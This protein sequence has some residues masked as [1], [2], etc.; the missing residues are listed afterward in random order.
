M[1]AGTQNGIEA[2][3]RAHGLRMT[4]PRRIILRILDT[5]FDHPD[6]EELHRRAV[7]IDARIALSTVYRTMRLLVEAG[8]VER[9]EFSEGRARYESA[10]HEHH[11][12]LIDLAT[13]HVIEFQSPE[14]EALQAQIAAKL[15]YRIVG[16]RLQL[17]G[18]AIQP[19]EKAKPTRKPTKKS[20]S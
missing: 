17:F 13:G 1:T 9:H 14:I 11:D 5:A 7:A 4:G 15:G 19:G 8:I 12:H 6:V 2:Q 10:S 3:C 16:H 18:V 20:I